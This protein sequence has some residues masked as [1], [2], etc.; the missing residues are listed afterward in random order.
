MCQSQSDT[1]K[2]SGTH[3]K[4]QESRGSVSDTNVSAVPTRGWRKACSQMLPIISGVLT[5]RTG[6]IFFA[7][8]WVEKTLKSTDIP[9]RGLQFSIIRPNSTECRFRRGPLHT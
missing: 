9:V 8:T 6:T 1:W 2:N 5:L 7:S 3:T 4:K